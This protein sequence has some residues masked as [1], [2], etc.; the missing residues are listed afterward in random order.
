MWVTIHSIIAHAKSKVS[1]G[2]SLDALNFTIPL[3]ASLRAAATK[4]AGSTHAT[5]EMRKEADALQMLD[6]YNKFEA[7]CARK[8]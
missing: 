4:L 6:K 3:S 1:L 5:P 2:L 7:P 8:I